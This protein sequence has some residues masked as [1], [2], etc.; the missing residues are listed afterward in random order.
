MLGDRTM[1]DD[2]L[3]GIKPAK[4]LALAMRGVH[5][6]ADREELR[7]ACK[8]VNKDDWDYFAGKRIQHGGAYLEGGLT[9]SRNVLKDS[10]G[11]LYISPTEADSVK[12][13]VYFKRYWGIKKWHDWVARRLAEK[14]ILVA[15]SGQVRQFFGRPD[16]ILTKAVAFEPQ[17][18]TTYATNLAAWRLWTDT[19]NRFFQ[20]GTTRSL[21]Q[22]PSLDGRNGGYRLRI[23][24]LHQVHDALI[25]QFYKNDTAWATSKIKSYFNNPLTIAGQQITIPY[26]GGY[27]ASWGGK[28][29]GSI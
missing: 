2:Y 7:H 23:E 29:E 18:N 21:R 17:A 25:G 24:P 19:D 26:E 20:P 14:P 5:V 15:A 22:V 3:A 4:V 16:D 28:Q 12:N 8:A 11:K 10:E 9:I 6:P 13:N 27:G 1:L